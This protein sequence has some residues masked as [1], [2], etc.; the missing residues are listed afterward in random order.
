[1]MAHLEKASEYA[2]NALHQVWLDTYSTGQLRS[3]ANLDAMLMILMLGF[4]GISI[5][6][7]AAYYS[8]SLSR[9]RPQEASVSS[10]TPEL[11][12][13]AGAQ[14]S[15]TIE[16]L[17]L[18]LLRL[19]MSDI[20]AAQSVSKHFKQV[21]QSSLPLQRAIFLKPA[22]R[23]QGKDM[24]LNPL[25]FQRFSIVFGNVSIRRQDYIRI[26]KAKNALYKS[27]VEFI[28]LRT[29]EPVRLQLKHDGGLT[30]ALPDKS[31]RGMYLTQ[32][33]CSV[34][35]GVEEQEGRLPITVLEG[36]TME[37]VIRESRRRLAGH[38]RPEDLPRILQRDAALSA[39]ENGMME[40]KRGGHA[41]VD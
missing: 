10:T 9:T 25:L 16:L 12:G 33:P 18:I 30:M 36:P 26:W 27:D 3:C 24:V 5:A 38:V 23:M 40:R 15:A 22:S 20:L 34:E 1:M 31:W 41:R 17:E 13:Q 2:I 6:A 32:P 37:E 28:S 19:P 39:C 8:W 29:K 21:I 4:I 11:R 14:V 7:A 35:F